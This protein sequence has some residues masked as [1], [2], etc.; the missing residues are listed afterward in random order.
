MI[1]WKIDPNKLFEYL[2]IFNLFEYLFIFN[3]FE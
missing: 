2:F 1:K 3:L